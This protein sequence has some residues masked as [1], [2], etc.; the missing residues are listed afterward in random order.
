MASESMLRDCIERDGGATVVV[1]A[2]GGGGPEAKFSV[3]EL[4]I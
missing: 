4:E 2:C 3:A 1:K